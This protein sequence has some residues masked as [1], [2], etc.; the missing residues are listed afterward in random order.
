MERES[1]S[2][3]DTRPEPATWKLHWPATPATAASV[4]TVRRTLMMGECRMQVTL[5]MCGSRPDERCLEIGEFVVANLRARSDTEI[6][7]GAEDDAD[8]KP[9]RMLIFMACRKRARGGSRM[10]RVCGE[11]ACRCVAE[12]RT[13]VDLYSLA[14]DYVIIWLDCCTTGVRLGLWA[15]NCHIWRKC[16]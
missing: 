16:A 12:S 8:E 6:V 15:G 3:A 9:G 1:S 14:S 5:E 11:D 7:Q 10:D 4:S 13:E 2:V